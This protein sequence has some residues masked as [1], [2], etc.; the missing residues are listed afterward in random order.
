MV[1]LLALRRRYVTPLLG[2][3]FLGSQQQS[4]P[5]GQVDITWSFEAGRLRMML[6]LGEKEATFSLSGAAPFYASEA[7]TFG[8]AAALLPPWS[9]AL[10]RF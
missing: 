1:R 8:S 2:T 6:N 9:L 7:V 4:T 5:E 10:V 3:R